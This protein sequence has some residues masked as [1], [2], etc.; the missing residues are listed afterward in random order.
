MRIQGCYR[1]PSSPSYEQSCYELFP[2]F[3]WIRRSVSGAS[4]RYFSTDGL[5]IWRTRALHPRRVLFGH[6]TFT[7][8][9]RCSCR[10]LWSFSIFVLCN[11]C[12]FLRFQG[13]T[14][15]FAGFLALC[16]AG[17]PRAV[18]SC[19]LII[20]NSK[21]SNMKNIYHIKK[22]FVIDRSIRTRLHMLCR[23]ILNTDFPLKSVY[24][25]LIDSHNETTHS[26]RVKS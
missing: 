9:R 26:V 18:N 17:I 21:P 11:R 5:T 20:K 10:W 2:V 24:F 13:R 16:I 22:N 4:R 3:E 12:A 25:R 15:G 14:R 6:R 8:H 7:R 19:K 23:L 1:V